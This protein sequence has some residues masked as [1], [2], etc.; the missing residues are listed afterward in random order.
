LYKI[1]WRNSEI[2][3]L[4]Q[5]ISS[6]HDLRQE[7]H[8]TQGL[9]YRRLGAN[10]ELE[11]PILFDKKVQIRLLDRNRVVIPWIKIGRKG[12][13][14]RFE[15]RDRDLFLEV[16]D[17]R[18][19][20]ILETFDVTA[21]A[22]GLPGGI[23]PSSPLQNIDWQRLRSLYQELLGPPTSNWEDRVHRMGPGLARCLILQRLGARFDSSYDD[24]VK[25]GKGPFSDHF[26]RYW[27]Q[28]SLIY[29]SLKEA[30]DWSWASSFL[31]PPASET[32]G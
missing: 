15:H 6:M 20:T 12:Q 23:V 19:Y 26:P 11:G 7:P 28:L 4:L 3:L 16:Y 29:S 21:P 5:E 2:T 10:I 24:A 17:C 13:A 25:L 1:E 27:K 31:I 30:Q 14:A 18:S 22:L 8:V 9:A 32:R